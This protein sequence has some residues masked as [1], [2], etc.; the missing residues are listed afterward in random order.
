MTTKILKCISCGAPLDRESESRSIRC[1]YCGCELHYTPHSKIKLEDLA[2][3]IN[4]IDISSEVYLLNQALEAEDFSAIT[5]YANK[6]IEKDP[7]LWMGYYYS[8]YG[9]FWSI[10]KCKISY[11]YFS[12]LIDEI[13][14]KIGTSKNL[15]EDLAPIIQ[16]ENDLIFNLCAIADRQG[17]IDFVGSNIIQSFELFAV[18]ASID[19]SSKHLANVISQYSSRLTCWAV[20]QLEQEA[21][22][23]NFTPNSSYLEYIYYCWKH[24]DITSG[25][26]TFDRFSRDFI[27]NSSNQELVHNI[28]E[29]RVEMIGK[30]TFEEKKSSFL[31]LF[32][33]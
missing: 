18:A 9:L 22:Q 27:K 20:D 24:F 3:R 8:A 1:S 14:F 29:M 10:D 19:E 12:K 32:S 13:I 21:I 25:V 30:G 23:S 31:G 5:D 26:K 7:T 15:A 28:R 4:P 11:E 33:R 2:A 6:L 16:F 17:K